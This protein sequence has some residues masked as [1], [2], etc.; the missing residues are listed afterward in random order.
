MIRVR[1]MTLTQLSRGKASNEEHH[2]IMEAIKEGDEEL[3][4]RLSKEH[5]ENAYAFIREKLAESHAQGV[6]YGKL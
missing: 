2:A 3:A 1:K 4:E 6:I 5:V